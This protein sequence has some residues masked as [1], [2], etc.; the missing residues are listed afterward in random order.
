MILRRLARPFYPLFASYCHNRSKAFEQRGARRGA[1]GL[2]CRSTRTQP[3]LPS[4]MSH[5]TDSTSSLIALPPAGPVSF[6][7]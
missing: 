5:R 7:R 2:T 1:D 3:A 6:F 4:S